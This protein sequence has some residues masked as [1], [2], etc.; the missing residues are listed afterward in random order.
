MLR[1]VMQRKKKVLGYLEDGKVV[2]FLVCDRKKRRGEK[3]ETGAWRQEQKAQQ[4]ALR[5]SSGV[6]LR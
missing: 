4:V 2:F 6:A 5:L 1:T 3:K